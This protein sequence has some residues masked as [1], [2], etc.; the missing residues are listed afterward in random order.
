MA[1][2]VKLGYGVH[3]PPQTAVH[4]EDSLTP[5]ALDDLE[6]AVARRADELAGSG[7]WH[8]SLNLHCWLEAEQEILGSAVSLASPAAN[9]S[10]P[11]VA[12]FA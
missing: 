5:Q 3:P 9:A 7:R 12:E 6:L 1:R 11:P 4:S 8:T 10:R 2:E